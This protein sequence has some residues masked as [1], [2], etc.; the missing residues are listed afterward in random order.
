[1]VSTFEISIHEETRNHYWWEMNNS[2]T[3]SRKLY[4]KNINRVYATFNQRNFCTFPSQATAK[5]FSL[6][7]SI[8]LLGFLRRLIFRQNHRYRF[9]L[10]RVIANLRYRTK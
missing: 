2:L 1:M 5:L 9:T 7:K 3:F 6:F 10:Q 8:L 4:W